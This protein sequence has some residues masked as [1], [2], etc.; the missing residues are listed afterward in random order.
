MKQ[1]CFATGYGTENG[2]ITIV[3]N[4]LVLKRT[5]E[6]GGDI[7]YPI[8]PKDLTVNVSEG[9]AATKMVKEFT[10]PEITPFLDYT[11]VFVKTGK[12][13]NDRSNW[14]CSIHA[15]ARD[16]AETVAAA[17]KAYA[18]NNKENLGLDVTVD[19]A[20]VTVN[21]PATGENYE[22]KL[23]DELYGEAVTGTAGAPA[24]M[25]A[26][27]VMDLAMKCAAD[28]GFEYTYDDFAGLYPN[29]PFNPLALGNGTDKPFYVV[30]IRFT[31]PRLMGTRE[32]SVYQ[33]IH[34]AFDTKA[35]ATALETAVKALK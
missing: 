24:Y 4:N 5:T 17:I 34:V 14:T 1:F 33:M 16:T 18:D 6:E 21:G 30:N 7:L 3:G 35:K 32:E 27:D 9:K 26:K 25:N 11:V 29:F 13:L 8:Y 23:G 15:S 10:V 31:E 12:G 20:K 22:I 2:N 28:A 19:G